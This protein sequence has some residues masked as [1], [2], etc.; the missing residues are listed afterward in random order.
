MTMVRYVRMP[1]FEVSRSDM[2]CLHIFIQWHY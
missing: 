2:L 1:E